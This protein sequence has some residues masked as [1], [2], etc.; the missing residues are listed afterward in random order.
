MLCFCL[1][2]SGR[3]GHTSMYMYIHF[4]CREKKSRLNN[5]IRWRKVLWFYIDIHCTHMH[6]YISRL[7]CQIPDCTLTT[8]TYVHW[9]CFLFFYSCLHCHHF[10]R[11]KIFLIL[12]ESLPCWFFYFVYMYIGSVCKQMLEIQLLRRQYSVIGLY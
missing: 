8:I 5:S 4:V 11:S 9:A 12:R 6:V 1:R 10:C 2:W 3:L 7:D